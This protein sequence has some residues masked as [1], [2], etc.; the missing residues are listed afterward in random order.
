MTTFTDV[1]TSPAPPTPARLAPTRP[2][3]WSMRRE[4]WESRSLYIAPLVAGAVVLFGFLIGSHRMHI[5]GIPPAQRDIV[6]VIPFDIAAMAI[7][8]TGFIVAVFYCL[9]A[10][11]NERRD[12]S[13]L[14]WKSLP[15]SDLT[16]VLAKASIPLI[17]APLVV[18]V[19]VIVTQL[20][21]L[22]ISTV[23]QAPHGADAMGMVW[24]RWPLIR[25][26]FVLL[27]G[28]ATATLWYAPIYGWLLLVSVWA[29]RAPFLWAVLPPLALCLI[30]AVA[31]GTSNV[32]SLLQDRL[33]GSFNLAFDTQGQHSPLID[34][35]QIDPARFFSSLGLWAGLAVAAALIAAAVWLR[36]SRE[37]T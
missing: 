29:R 17:I 13:I 4:V 10:L 14:F 34:L 1:E 12:R 5:S 30:E 33:S 3:Y 28:L 15:V 16:T 37:P 32:S 2:L 23:V 18:F 6:A 21:M 36:R 35:S 19:V 11:H 9:G 26:S 31:F 20:I 7:M 8:F 22:L 24:A 25:M 27:Y